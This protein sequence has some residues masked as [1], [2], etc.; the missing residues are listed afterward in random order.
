MPKEIDSLPTNGLKELFTDS[1]IF[2]VVK[3]NLTSAK[4]HTHPRKK[5]LAQCWR[6]PL[7]SAFNTQ[8]THMP[9][10]ACKTRGKA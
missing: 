3:P 1:E 8:K 6:L 2:L 4:P 10:Q 7:P 5:K 9:T